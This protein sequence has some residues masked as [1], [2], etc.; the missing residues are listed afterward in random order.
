MITM[1][2]R[3][4]SNHVEISN[5]LFYMQIRLKLNHV[6]VNVVCMICWK[7]TLVSSSFLHLNY[8]SSFSTNSIPRIN[9][10]IG[11]WNQN[12]REKIN[13]CGGWFPFDVIRWNYFFYFYFWSI[14]I[15]NL[16]QMFNFLITRAC[17]SHQSWFYQTERV[18]PS[19]SVYVYTEESVDV[20]N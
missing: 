11:A 2:R 10:V 15:T 4:L 18:N 14:D 17:M 13:S 7:L 12:L 9:Q 16:Y 1:I 3:R 20:I 5:I 6:L 8:L 19:F